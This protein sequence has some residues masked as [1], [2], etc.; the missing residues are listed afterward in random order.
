MNGALPKRLIEDNDISAVTIDRISKKIYWA[1]DFDHVYRSNYNGEWRESVIPIS[2]KILSLAVINNQLFYS[3]ISKAEDDSIES[4]LKSCDMNV[5]GC[6]NTTVLNIPFRNPGIIKSFD[7][8]QTTVKDPCE[9]NNGDCQHLC[10]SSKGSKPTCACN[11]GLK[12]DSNSKNCTEATDILIYIQGDYVKAKII[13]DK[14][15]NFT[16]Y[17]WPIAH[18]MGSS[19]YID[20][21][22]NPKEN[23]IFMSNRRSILEL[24]LKNDQRAVNIYNA[25]ENYVIN[26]ISL[27]WENN[28]LYYIEHGT[29]DL[30]DSISMLGTAKGEYFEKA[31]FH[32]NFKSDSK[33]GLRPY[34]LVYDR[35]HRYVYFTAQEGNIYPIHRV[36]VDNPSRSTDVSGDLLYYKTRKMLTVDYQSDRLYWIHDSFDRWI[37][38]TNMNGEDVKM[39]RVPIVNMLYISV[40]GNWL[41]IGNSTGIWR[42]DKTKGDSV[43]RIVPTLDEFSNQE[44]RGA[45]VFTRQYGYE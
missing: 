3:E 26:D 37:K 9:E 23:K 14:N 41:Y 11:L 7:V 12:L 16:D 8:S 38:H 36:K 17:I 19:E 31:F 18:E 4:I 29:S 2:K 34:S 5:T 45:Q 44:I 40:K 1:R 6:F 43:T 15:D 32:L 13:E 42:L 35:K 30:G 28:Y 25:T 22:Y 24:I 10:L 27:D 20:F 21:D 39:F 33:E